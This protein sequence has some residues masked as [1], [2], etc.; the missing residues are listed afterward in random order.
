MPWRAATN[1]A[2]QNRDA[3]APQAMP[4]TSDAAV[5]DPEKG[6]LGFLTKFLLAN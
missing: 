3:P 2:A 1:P 5:A 6:G 4:K